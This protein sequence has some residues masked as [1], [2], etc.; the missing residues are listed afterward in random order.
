MLTTRCCYSLSG[1]TANSTSRRNTFDHIL[2]EQPVESFCWCLPAERFPGSRVQCVRNGAQ[3]CGAVL[4]EVRPLREVL[5]E[6]AGGVL[7]AAT[8]P[9]AL[10]V[11]EVNLETG[12]DPQLRRFR[13]I[14]FVRTSKD[15]TRPRKPAIFRTRH[16]AAI[17]FCTGGYRKCSPGHCEHAGAFFLPGRCNCIQ[18]GSL[19]LEPQASALARDSRRSILHTRKG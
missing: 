19:S 6:Q 2:F 7:V 11:A 3:F 9:R 1:S 13:V 15:D 17:C 4:A 18:G 8:L 12:G 16:A 10:W 5:S 14:D